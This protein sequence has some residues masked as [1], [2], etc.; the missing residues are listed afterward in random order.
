MRPLPALQ[1]DALQYVSRLATR[2]WA[3]PDWL[4]VNLTLRC[5]LSCVM[6]T[7]CYDSPELTLDELYGLID[8]ASAWGVRVFNPLGGEPFVRKDLEDILRHAVERRMFVTITT[9][10]TLIT[11]ARAERIA[12]LPPEQL[13]MNVS[14]DGLGA[15]HDR[16]RG[17]GNFQRMI[18][19]YR[20]IRAADRAAGQPRRTIVANVILHRL[21]LGELPDLLTF[22]EVEDFSGVQ[23]LN[24][25][26]NPKDPGVAG[27]WFEA[28][29]IPALTQLVA[30]LV[31][32]CPLPLRTSK[33]DILRIPRYYTEALTP[34]E[35]PC[36]AGWKELYV[37]ADGTAIM[38]DGK[39][40]F[41]AGAFGSVRDQTLRELWSS[42]AIRER[43][44]V[45]KACTTP[46]LQNCYLRREADSARVIAAGVLDHARRAVRGRLPPKPRPFLDALG[47]ELCDLSAP[48][49]PED[50]GSA[51]WRQLVRGVALSAR[52]ALHE[53]SRDEVR[54]AGLRDRGV[55]CFDRGFMGAEVF[56]EFLGELRAAGRA[57]GRLVLAGRGD[58]LLHPELSRIWA[59]CKL[60]LARGL[61]SEV[62][63][64]S[65][66]P[67]E[68]PAFARRISP[69][70]R[71]GAKPFDG[72]VP[73]VSWDGWL[74]K[75]DDPLL[76]RPVGDALKVGLLRLSGA[77]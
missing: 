75:G 31:E 76:Q 42:P 47:F 43:R 9:N 32:E 34:L 26:R 54:W 58:P 73:W 45:V 77:S 13:H 71:S 22:L 29:D 18:D 36:W 5:N 2:G 6:C 11:P 10:G 24:L 40:D 17:R 4:T 59:A 44:A 66:T 37:N 49:S 12:Q 51:R 23:I 20:A 67:R 46:C 39:L 7:T 41:P 69:V 61:V 25:F 3:P 16:V 56:E 19:G 1:R 57:L 21:N 63:V 38:C 55:L 62:L 60:A 74:A 48:E 28:G 52:G 68:L 70:R 35:A 27:M 64:R 50:P 15:T 65:S 30:W 53:A 72:D 33:A 8:Q 14:I